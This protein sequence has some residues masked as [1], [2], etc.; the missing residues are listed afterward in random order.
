MT[1]RSH[2]HRFLACVKYRKYDSKEKES[3]IK[4]KIMDLVKCPGHTAPLALVKFEDN[5]EDY[6][7]A[8][9]NI[10]VNDTIESGFTAAP[11]TGNTL[12]L[13]NI[14][15]G[16]LIYNIETFPGDGGKLCR[17][18]GTFARILTKTRTGVTVELPSKK[19]K[20]F[21]PNCRATIGIIAGSGRTE[22]PWVKAGKKHHATRARGRLYPRTSPVAMNAVDHPFGSG[23]GRK[24]S[25]IKPVGPHTPPGRKVG[26][27]SSRRTGRKK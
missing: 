17:A 8:P 7:I 22:K 16:T 9:E 2:S 27:V 4:G 14:E 19:Q 25:K 23:R 26:F 10:K 11:K 3:V 15:E 20:V 18:S 13:Q 12:P 24:V 5:K 1:Y 21:D 6:M